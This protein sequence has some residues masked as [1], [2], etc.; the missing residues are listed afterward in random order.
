MSRAEFHFLIASDCFRLLLIASDCFRLRGQVSRAEFHKAMPALGLD[1]PKETIDEL[2]SSWD[3]DGGG[4]LGYAEL[5]RILSE[6]RR[7]KTAE[8]PPASVSEKSPAGMKSAAVGV[9]AVA[10]MSKMKK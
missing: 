3:K 4:E 7:Q 1:V 5:R 10:A 9:K 2:F 6:P 8:K